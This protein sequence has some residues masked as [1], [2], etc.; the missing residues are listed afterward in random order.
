MS[1]KQKFTKEEKQAYFKEMRRRWQL[2]KS[3]PEDHQIMIAFHASGLKV[4]V[5]GFCYI[6][7]QM[8]EQGLEGLPVIDAKTYQGWFDN[9][10]RVKK[11]EKSTLQ[12]ITWVTAN[13]KKIE[14]EEKE[15]SF[16]YPKAYH[17]F[18]RSQVEEMEVK[19]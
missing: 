4:S 19:K 18:H 13:S 5:G 11:G 9:G 10:F 1:T 15:S 2:A 12:G 17:L 16:S 6:A 8:A 3:L 7:G 14:D